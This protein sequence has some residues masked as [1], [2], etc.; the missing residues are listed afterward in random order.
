MVA[1][2]ARSA[3]SGGGRLGRRCRVQGSRGAKRQVVELLVLV[4]ELHLMMV[5]V[6]HLLLTVAVVVRQLERERLERERRERGGRGEGR[7]VGER[8]AMRPEWRECRR[9]GREAR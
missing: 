2:K 4:L 1:G 3:S 9:R 6:L 5:M 7:E 8:R